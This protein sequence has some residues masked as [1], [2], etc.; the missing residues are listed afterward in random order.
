MYCYEIQ[1]FVASEERN[2]DSSQSDSFNC[3]GESDGGAL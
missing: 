3:I 1:Q 2:I